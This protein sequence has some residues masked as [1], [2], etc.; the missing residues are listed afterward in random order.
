MVGFVEFPVALAF[1]DGSYASRAEFDALH[2]SCTVYGIPNNPHILDI[3]SKR[4]CFFQLSLLHSLGSESVT[5][6]MEKLA[7]WVCI[8]VFY[9]FFEYVSHSNIGNAC[10]SEKSI[11][12]MSWRKIEF[13]SWKPSNNV[14]IERYNL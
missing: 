5:R 10:C 14:G 9:L 8:I 4:I 6:N 1:W 13:G 3:D 7:N 2:S 12:V 11:K